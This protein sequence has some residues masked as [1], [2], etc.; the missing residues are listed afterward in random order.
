[1][2]LQPT[3]IPFMVG[4][5]SLTAYSSL[6]NFYLARAARTLSKELLDATDPLIRESLVIQLEWFVRRY[7]VSNNALLMAISSVSLFGLMVAACLFTSSGWAPSWFE[8]VA[9]SLM[10]I[11]GSSALFATLLSMYEAFVARRSLFTAV[12]A[13]VAKAG[14]Y[15]KRMDVSR[16]LGE[17][18]RGIRGAVRP[19]LYDMVS[20]VSKGGEGGDSTNIV[21][22]KEV[23]A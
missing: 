19:E 5:I 8:P 2:D 12:A 4:S 7:K 23:S 21:I 1:M 15:G 11:G 22:Q 3:F 16:E 13:C 9:G 17:I 14:P 6:R 20:R 10:L 18:G